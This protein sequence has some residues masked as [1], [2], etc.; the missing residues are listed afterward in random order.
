MGEVSDIGE[1]LAKMRAEKRHAWVKPAIAALCTVAG[2]F[3]GSIWTARGM[4]DSQIHELEKLTVRLSGIDQNLRDIQAKQE[5]LATHLQE[6]AII[7]ESNR[8]C[9]AFLQ[10]DKTSSELYR[11]PGSAVK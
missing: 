2:T 11:R 1:L 6:Q 9:C 3:G 5:M 4:L 8:V 7:G 10:R